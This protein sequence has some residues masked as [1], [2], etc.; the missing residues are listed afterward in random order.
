METY[1]YDKF[2]YLTVLGAC[3]QGEDTW[4]VD[5]YTNSLY[6]LNEKRRELQFIA[7]LEVNQEYVEAEYTHIVEHNGVLFILPQNSYFICIYNICS[8]K[9]RKIEL[10]CKKDCSG[11][12][13]IGEV[14]YQGYL[15]IFSCYEKY[16][17]YK[18]NL[19]DLTLEEEKDWCIGLQSL[20]FPR[21]R[22]L[23]SS[24]IAEENGIV[25]GLYD[26]GIVLSY[27]LDTREFSKVCSLKE[28]FKI[29]KAISR[30]EDR[31]YFSAVGCNEIYRIN[32][33]DNAQERVPI[34]FWKADNP[35]INALICGPNM[36]LLPKY[37]KVIVRYDVRNQELKKMDWEVPEIAEG[38]TER[39][40]LYGHLEGQNLIL[41][42]YKHGC[43]LKID[44]AAGRTIPEFLDK[45]PQKSALEILKHD[46]WDQLTVE[47]SG[48]IRE[49]ICPLSVYIM[50]ISIE[51]LHYSKI[52]KT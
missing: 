27:R 10:P 13:V 4:A 21:S 3:K 36:Y 31:I 47:L 19:T 26:T 46:Y 22:Y 49:E 32:P 8:D 23:V 45:D 41:Y 37:G 29:D 48:S 15:Y 9:L 11:Y 17:P 50:C 16:A 14:F 34:E 52:V 28:N 40:F 6:R 2:K 7:N 35:V 43:R 20:S 25:F 42:L 33:E 44:L 5:R 12:G 30:Y 38:N 24:I 39:W 51:S 1:F 18:I